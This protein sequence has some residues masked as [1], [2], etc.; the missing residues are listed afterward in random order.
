MDDHEDPQDQEDL[1]D[2]LA[3]EA[4]DEV[5]S[6]LTAYREALLERKAG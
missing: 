1:A 3:Q 5:E 6:F 4:A 2:E